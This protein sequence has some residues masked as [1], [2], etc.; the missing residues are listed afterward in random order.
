MIGKIKQQ[1]FGT[2]TRGETVTLYEMNTPELIVRVLDYGATIQAIMV[3]DK[4]EDWVDV[5]LGYDTIKDYQMHVGYLGACVGRVAN[6]LGDAQFTLNGKV[7]SLSQNKGKNHVHGGFCGFDKYVW[8]A[9]I[10]SNGVKF[11][12][13]SPDGEEGYPGNLMVSVTYCVKNGTLSITYDAVSDQDTLCNLTNHS[14]FNLNGDDTVLSHT[15][16]INADHFLENS[17]E[18][19]PTGKILSV[20]GTPMD[21]RKP[22]KIGDSIMMDNEQLKNSGGY[23][24]N[25]CLQENG[26]LF[27]AAVLHSEQSGITMR[28][29][30]TMPGMQLYTANFL[31]PWSGKGGAMY[32]ERDAVCLE[33]QFY[34][35]AMQCRGFKKPILKANERYYN[36]T[37]YS[38]TNR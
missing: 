7:Y 12:R 19:M 16:Q 9:E 3:R 15:L 35:N 33:T 13:V 29:S 11:S 2:T 8:H 25:F 32:H 34:P 23:D 31:G 28:V 24:H 21:F 38:F 5:V 20:E 14:Y 1:S 6:R 36:V 22:K 17:V 4:D 30:T 26:E 37:E 27:E 10:L 18:C